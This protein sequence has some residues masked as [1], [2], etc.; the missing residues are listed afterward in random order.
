MNR[1]IDP[2]DNRRSVALC[3]ICHAGLADPM[4]ARCQTTS[5]QLEA[6]EN[7]WWVLP[8][9]LSG[10]YYVSRQIARGALGAIYEAFRVNGGQPGGER[11]ALKFP[12]LDV[13]TDAWSRVKRELAIGQRLGG[14]PGVPAYHG[15]EKTPVSLYVVMD[16][17][18]GTPVRD[19]V[20]RGPLRFTHHEIEAFALSLAETLVEIHRR[21]I[22]HLDLTPGSVLWSQAS[23]G[24]P[25]A[26]VVDFASA[27][28]FPA[29]DSPQDWRGVSGGGLLIGTPRYMAP[30]SVTVGAEVGPHTDV[31]GFGLLL[32]ECLTGLRPYA[33]YTDPF[34]MAK[35]IRREPP[36]PPDALSGWMTDVVLRCI[37]RE[38][39]RRPSDMS[40]V[41]QLLGGLNA[42]GR[43]T[44]MS[45]LEFGSP[46]EDRS[47][48]DDSSPPVPL[49]EVSDDEFVH[50]GDD[51][52]EVGEPSS[53]PV[54][55]GE[56]GLSTEVDVIDEPAF[57]TELGE[58]PRSDGDA[59]ASGWRATFADD[60][61]GS[62]AVPRA[63][64]AV[65]PGPVAVDGPPVGPAWWIWLVV[66]GLSVAGF[67]THRALW[68]PG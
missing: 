52:V 34:E 31:Y 10:R 15:I 14:V 37:E 65:E 7:G 4:S 27:R 59:T 50:D 42:I 55:A 2:V 41:V 30:E 26:V 64:R 21:G 19:L 12:R 43:T 66:S 36:G 47:R 9:V 61:L 1:N 54:S 48:F 33:R 20:R 63:A 39:R 49:I 46:L 51:G 44:E 25:S 62:H 57:V 11:L 22:I 35:A 60:S 24:P 53:T 6:P 5:C 67:V 68:I 3:P 16:L 13:S 17:A 40:A 28:S 32:W 58:H 29:D 18:E 23:A 45:V 38:P 56:L 8:Q